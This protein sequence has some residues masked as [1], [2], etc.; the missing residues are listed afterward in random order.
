MTEP[1]TELHWRLSPWDRH[2]HAFQTL[3]EVV[4]EA[5]CSHSALTRRL[6]EPVSEDRRCYGCLFL[7]GDDLANHYGDLDRYAP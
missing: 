1:F 3:G 5:V 2:V 4:S 7:H 6:A